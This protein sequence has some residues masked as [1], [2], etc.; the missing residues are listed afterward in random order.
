MNINLKVFLNVLPDVL[1]STVLLT[2]LLVL[3][4]FKTGYAIKSYIKNN[5][6]VSYKFE[7]FKLILS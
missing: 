5:S 3:Q 1:A 2:C 6:H 7:Y 4:S